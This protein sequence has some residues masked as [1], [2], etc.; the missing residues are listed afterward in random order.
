MSHVDTTPAPSSYQPLTP[1]DGNV[2]SREGAGPQCCCTTATRLELAVVAARSVA[3]RK[4]LQD[5]QLCAM[6]SLAGYG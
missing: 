1:A 3:A 2:L 5:Q 4:S 6:V